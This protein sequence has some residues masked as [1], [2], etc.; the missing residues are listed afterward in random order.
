MNCLQ[1]LAYL[2]IEIGISRP[3]PA[4][5]NTAKV[6][7]GSVAAAQQFNTRQAAFG[8]KAGTLS[9]A[10]ARYENY[11]QIGIEPFPLIA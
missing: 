4:L 11:V 9:A 6:R 7:N 5:K 2:R 1:Q 3:H 10:P 8:C